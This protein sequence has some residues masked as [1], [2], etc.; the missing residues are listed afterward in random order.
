MIALRNVVKSMRSSLRRSSAAMSGD[1]KNASPARE[2]LLVAASGAAARGV[3]VSL[4]LVGLQSFYQDVAKGAL[5]IGA[6]MIQELRFR[7][8]GD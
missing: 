7:R 1:F 8:S 6:V 4:L 2:G 3:S 5:L